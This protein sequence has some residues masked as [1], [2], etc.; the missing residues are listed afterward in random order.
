M[1]FSARG[2][3]RRYACSRWSGGGSGG[4][5]RARSVSSA[6]ARAVFRSRQSLFKILITDGRSR[7]RPPT[8]ARGA[9]EHLRTSADAS[10]WASVCAQTSTATAAFHARPAP[11]TMSFKR[12]VEIGRIGLI[13]YGPDAGKL[14][15]IVDVIDNNRVLVDGPAPITGV[16]RHALNIRG[17]S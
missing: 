11:S 5:R 3:S 9:A 17:C 2:G 4:G 15:T 16:H 12:F 10:S 6:Q 14:C 1:R 8:L 13:T 7:R